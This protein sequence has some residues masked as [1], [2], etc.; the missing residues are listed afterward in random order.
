MR[1]IKKPFHFKGTAPYLAK[2]VKM[3]VRP[4]DDLYFV[5]NKVE[6]PVNPDHLKFNNGFHTTLVANSKAK[7]GSTEHLLSALWGMGIDGARIELSDE[8]VPTINGHAQ[9]FVDLIKGAGEV[10]IAGEVGELKVKETIVFDDGTG[11]LAI[12]RPLEKDECSSMSALI[13]FHEVIGEQY[14]KVDLTPEAYEKEICWART[15]FRKAMDV[16]SWEKVKKRIPALP[17]KIEDSPVLAWRDGG[18]ITPPRVNTEPVRH[19]ILDAIGDLACLGKR[20]KGH[21]TLVRPG[22]EFNRKLVMYLD[23]L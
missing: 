23:K 11:S 9:T 16:K 5:V 13:Q 8:E 12:L 17:K 14:Y 4:C 19:K 18:W 15:F 21:I 7:V 10:E 3:V 20:I 22:H 1:T 2:E 6:I